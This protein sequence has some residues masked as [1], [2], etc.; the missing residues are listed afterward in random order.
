MKILTTIT[1]LS[2]T[3]VLTACIHESSYPEEIENELNV[4]DRIV[5]DS[6]RYKEAKQKKS[7]TNCLL[8]VL[9]IPI[10]TDTESMTKSTENTTSIIWTL[11]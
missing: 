3:T 10:R 8:C 7:R 6:S 9:K 11:P 4:L 2:F 1:L 5:D